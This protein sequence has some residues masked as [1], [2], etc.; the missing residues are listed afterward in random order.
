MTAT[1]LA[2][3][4]SAAYLY[5][6]HLDGAALAWEYLRRNPDYRQAWRSHARHSAAVSGEWGLIW[7]ENPD[8]DARFAQPLWQPHP[9]VRLTAIDDGAPDADR[10]S[11]WRLPGRKALFHDG[12]HLLLSLYLVGRTLRLALSLSISDGVAFAYVISASADTDVEWHAAQALHSLLRAAPCASAHDVAQ[13]P[14]RVATA[15]MR[16]LQALDGVI[17]GASLREIAIAV[18]GR[19]RVDQGWYPDS[20]L[21][22]QT[23][24]LIRRGRA[25]MRIDYRRLVA[26]T[27]SPNARRAVA[28]RGR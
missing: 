1:S 23:R 28:A 9:A 4:A 11:L 8:L 19:H 10:F 24:Y 16:S 7:L 25:F 6:L 26:S 18:F 21:R 12:R 27:A 15:H 13:R 14:D 22:A 3:R 17:A 5:A 20:E 2:W